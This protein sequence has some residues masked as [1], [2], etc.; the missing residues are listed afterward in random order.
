MTVA[1]LLARQQAEPDAVVL[2]LNNMFSSK[3]EYRQIV[4]VFDTL[5]MAQAFERACRLPR[6][7]SKPH[8]ATL[9]SYTT[10][11]VDYP[12]VGTEIQDKMVRSYRPDSIL[13]DFNTPFHRDAPFQEATTD[14]DLYSIPQNPIAPTGPIVMEH[15]ERHLIE[16]S[17]ALLALWHESGDWAPFTVD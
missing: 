1:D 3:I 10:R 6:D 8:N 2:V 4:A 7:P 17:I 16:E 9:T 5:D 12:R 14:L 11:R 13:W 15:P